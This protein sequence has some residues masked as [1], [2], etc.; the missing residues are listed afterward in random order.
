M[1]LNQVLGFFTYFLK[2]VLLGITNQIELIKELI[3][4]TKDFSFSVVKI[5]WIM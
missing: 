4:L 5:E 2:K 1:L 3:I